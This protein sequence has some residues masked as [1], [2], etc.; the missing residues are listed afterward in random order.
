MPDR[1]EL[2]TFE[3]V[4]DPPG[5][6]VIDRIERLRYQ[7]HTSGVVSPTPIDTGEC[8]FPVDRAVAVG[9]EEIVLP[10]V[11]GVCVRDG[12]GE[13]IT[14][15]GHLE[16]ESLGKGTYVLEL[17]AQVQTY[18]VVEG[19]L[20][21]TADLVEVRMEFG[22]PQEVIIGAL[23]RH[24]RPV[25]TVTT[26]DDPVDMMAAVSSF[27]SALKTTNPERS[28]PFNRGHPPAITLGESLDIP[29]PVERPATGIQ[30]EVPPEYGAIYTAAPLSYYTGAEIVPGSTPRLVT[31]SG[32]EHALDKPDG[33]ERGVEQTLKQLFLLDC[34]VR[35]EGIYTIELHERNEIEKQLDLDWGRLYNLPIAERVAN[36]L[37]IPYALVRDQVPEWRLTVHIEPGRSTV[38]QLPFV[39][40]DLAVVRTTDGIPATSPSGTTMPAASDGGVITRSAAETSSTEEKSYVEPEATDSL[41]Q[42]W[43]GP[44]IPIGASKLTQEAFHNRLNL[45]PT[46]GEI[47]IT[48]VLNDERM[49]EERDL[50][51][52]TYGNRA[53]LPFDVT[54]KRDLTTTEL[55]DQLRQE[56]SFL[57]Y[58][59]HTEE[60]GF[61][62][63][64]GKLDAAT[65]SETGVDAFLLNACN[66]YRQG[67][68]LIEAGAVGG[69]VTLNDIINDGAVR[70][71]ETIARL[72]NAGF[73]L[74]AA[75]TIARDE[76]IL[77]GQYIVVGDGGMTVT[78]AASRTP[79]L[80]DIRR[81]GDEFA[82]DI[83]M[84]ATD[85][86]GLGT[87]YMP[88]LPDNDEYFLNSGNIASFQVP[89]D[90]LADFLKLEDVPVRNNGELHWSSSVSVEELE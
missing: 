84:Y 20:E 39:V 79:N 21:I 56:H 55:R 27:G 50:V 76:S 57:H 40:D 22:D 66:S 42:A 33:L 34:I 83:K 65:L 61:E 44:S 73:P 72:L 1:D 48:I 17:S 18:L 59:G 28:F 53:A 45:E 32:F 81:T 85:D 47:S 58:I 62:C 8:L 60:D 87:V 31:D 6:E 68:H 7:L 41:E 19:P 89:K 49:S 35:T 78:Q 16:S 38:E 54:V 5:I 14:N 43:I 26:T 9:T 29:E 74:R 12:S 63:A 88:H 37:E 24:D 11:V 75:L 10:T 25:A 77:G 71:G 15:V 4:E 90:D 2:L 46:D 3:S 80:L 69:I 23:S 67:I 86:A 36:Y 64:D 70:I 82:M 52:Q 30:L 51:N 13:M